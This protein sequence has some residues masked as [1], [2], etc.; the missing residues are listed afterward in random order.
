MFGTHNEST[1]PTKLLDYFNENLGR[2]RFSVRRRSVFTCSEQ[3]IWMLVMCVV[4]AFPDSTRRPEVTKPRHYARVALLEDW[5]DLTQSQAFVTDIQRGAVTIGNITVERPGS[6]V[7]QT[8]L[9]RY[10]NSFMRG[11]GLVVRTRF[12]ERTPDMSQQPLISSA[13]PYYPDVASAAQ[14]W[15]ELTEY[16]GFSDARNREIVFLLPE[17]RAFFTDAHSENGT[18][19]LTVAGSD[20]GRHQFRVKGAY[21]VG[22]FIRHFE[23]EFRGSH[24]ELPVPDEVERLEYLLLDSE[25]ETRDFLSEDPNGHTSPVRKRAGM[26]DSSIPPGFVV[27]QEDSGG[28]RPLH[29]S[30]EFNTSEFNEAPFNSPSFPLRTNDTPSAEGGTPNIWAEQSRQILTRLQEIEGTLHSV[31]AVLAQIRE[32]NA[33]A[34][35]LQP[36]PGMGHN[37]PPPEASLVSTAIEQAIAAQ[38]LL[39]EEAAKTQPSSNALNLSALAF[40]GAA[41]FAGWL[42]NQGKTFIEEAVKS[43]GT[44]F[45]ANAINVAAFYGS[46]EILRTELPQVTDAIYTFLRAIGFPG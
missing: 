2:P 27:G 14:D 30:A 44:K 28:F 35:L 23:T 32:T 34:G 43:A 19:K 22:G 36:I 20:V 17:A 31:A 13:E 5:L 1:P 11:V 33:T 45:G 16:H 9:V 25:G 8:E 39:E 10:Q 38:E 46:L 6:P 24:A 29:S 7:W 3:G 40:Q 37:Q 26:A 4:H 18:L 42:L 21:W 12:E 41:N 15:L